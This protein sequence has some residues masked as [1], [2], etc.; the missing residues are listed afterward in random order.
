M[1]HLRKQQNMITD[2]QVKTTEWK[3]KTYHT[4]GTIPKLNIKITR[5]SNSDITNVQIHHRSLSWLGT[6]TSIKC[7][8]VRLVLWLK[9]TNASKMP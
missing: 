9:Y 5:K 3:S 1:Y 8:G 6:G 2:I 4:V 7:G